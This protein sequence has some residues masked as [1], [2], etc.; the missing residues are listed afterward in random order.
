MYKSKGQATHIAEVRS[1]LRACNG[2]RVSLSV[3]ETETETERER[4]RDRDRDRE[5]Y[6]GGQTIIL[7]QC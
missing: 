1:R 6:G 4:D 3:R 5:V 2:R 7:L